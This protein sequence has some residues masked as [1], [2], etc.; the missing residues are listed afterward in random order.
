MPNRVRVAD[1]VWIATALLHRQHPDAED[2]TV[3]QI[4]RRAWS[5]NITAAESLRPGVQVHAYLHCVANKP[6]NPGRYRMLTETAKGR[7]RLYRPGDPVDPGRS[8]G[9]DRPQDDAVPSRYRF[10][11]DWYLHE[12]VGDG[13]R[14]VA[15][16]IL[17]LQ[18]LGKEIWADEDADAYV[19]R[20]RE[21]WL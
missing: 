1:E 11:I 10:L 12:Y 5:E 7:R 15:D 3:G 9:K 16:P 20:L 2:F 14:S 6:P 19:H 13:E 18:G 4:V 17:S 8:A 21:G